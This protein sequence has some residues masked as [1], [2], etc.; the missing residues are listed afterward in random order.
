MS[1]SKHF[2]ARR[3]GLRA[4]TQSLSHEG[5]GRRWIPAFAGMTVV[6][7]FLL[8]AE[9]VAAQKFPGVGRTATPAEIAAWDIDVRPDF[10][11]LPKGSGSVKLGQQVWEAKCESCHGA[12]GESNEVFTPIAGGTTKQ[13]IQNGRVA[14][15]MR[16]DFPQRS[17][18]MKLAHVATLWDYIN[19]AMPWNAPKTLS[20]EEVYAVTAYVLHLGDIVPGDFVLSDQNIAAVQAKLPNRNGLATYTPLWDVRGKGDTANTACMANC[21]TDI[22]V[23]SALPAHARN[24]HGNL[25]EQN[26][27][28]GPVRG[29]DTTRPAQ[30]PVS[31]ATPA[32]APVPATPAPAAKPAAESLARKFACSAC[33]APAS[34]L[35]GPSYAEIAKRYA[36][37]AN[38]K[39]LLTEKI[40]KGG[41]GTWGA[42]PMPPHPQISEADLALL[43]EWSLAGGK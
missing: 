22:K 24:A 32:P 26:R 18:L 15:L 20:T 14:N 28:I 33:H 6:L 38:A 27:L 11:G 41:S 43:V 35:V 39:N 5:A 17:T 9:I 40:R 34:K 30:T 42:I 8:H 7:G 23:T 21:T 3:P 4:G 16:P 36:G 2:T 13:D 1:Q 10:K 29:V 37:N 31:A 12:F 19:R 25:A